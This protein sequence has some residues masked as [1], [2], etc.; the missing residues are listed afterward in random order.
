MSSHL[1]HKYSHVFCP[2]K[3]SYLPSP[4][5]QIFCHQL[6]NHISSK[7][8]TFQPNHWPQ[9]INQYITHVW[10]FLL[11][12]DVN[13]QVHCSKFFPLG[14]FPFPTTLQGCPRKGQY[15]FSCPLSGGP[16]IPC[17]CICKPG[18]SLLFLH[19]C[20]QG[21]PHETTGAGRVE[22]AE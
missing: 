20:S 8:L 21:A 1:G 4:L 19:Y 5:P 14:G 16:S 9:Y 3:E 2:F 11:F 18:P 15:H 17:R 7:T 10:L 6:P 12:C 22:K 13:Y